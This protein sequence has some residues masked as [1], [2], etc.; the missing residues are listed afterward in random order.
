MNNEENT[1]LSQQK[2]NE[3]D[4]RYEKYKLGLVEFTDCEKVHQRLR[5]KLRKTSK[6][7]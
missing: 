5:S 6:K 3:L 7:G 1:K 4:R 2:K